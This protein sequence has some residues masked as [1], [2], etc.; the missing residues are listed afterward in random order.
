LG[1]INYFSG[2]DKMVVIEYNSSMENFLFDAISR[3][4]SADINFDVCG[5]VVK[6]LRE[7]T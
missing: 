1:Q 2:F 7:G 5:G 3:L 6:K 4:T